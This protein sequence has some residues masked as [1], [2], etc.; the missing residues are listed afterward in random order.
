[1]AY[2]DASGDNARLL[3]RAILGVADFSGRSRRTE[4]LYYFIACA[5]IGAVFHFAMSMTVSFDMAVR[6][7]NA[8]SLLFMVPVFAL[9]V[10]RL[11]DQGR[12]GWWGLLQPL[13][14]LLSVPR[15]IAE[16]R[17]DLAAI[18]AQR[19]TPI[20]ILSGIVGLAILILYFLPGSD[21]A[22]R[23]GPDPRLE[24]AR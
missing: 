19:F 5:L 3:R 6:L 12:S 13:M 21:G 8:L 7:G 10:R 18:I 11:H 4:L 22:N 20:G 9:F 24:D 16:L 1:M 15:L 2:H 14:L 17:G 23:Y